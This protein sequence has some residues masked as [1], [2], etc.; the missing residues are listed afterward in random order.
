MVE[1]LSGWSGCTRVKGRLYEPLRVVSP[2]QGEPVVTVTA[3]DQ[4][5]GVSDA[6]LYSIERE[7]QRRAQLV[8]HNYIRNWCG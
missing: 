3:I 8:V 7:R 4:D 5:A 2:P 6:I 1:L